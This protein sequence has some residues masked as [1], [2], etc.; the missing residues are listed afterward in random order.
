VKVS[1]TEVAGDARSR[2]GAGL[3]RL[4]D[5]KISL[6][7]FSALFLGA[8]AAARDGPISVPWLLLTVVGIFAIEVAKNA[9]G[10][11]F[12]F[13]SGTDLAVAREDRT[14]FS[15]G[16]R[17]L[18]ERLLT[19]KQTA[20]IAGVAYSLGI[21]A[22][23][24]IV[25]WREPRVLLL[26]FVGVAAALFYQAP[27]LRLSYR[28]LGEVAVGLCYGPLLTA[29][30]YLVQRGHVTR[31]VIAASLPLGLMIADFLLINEFP[32]ARADSQARKRTLVVRLGR[33]RASLLYGWVAAIAFALV[34]ALPSIGSP[35]SVWLG[36]LGLPPA[37]RTA[38]ILRAD[39]DTTA[40]L[41]PAQILT[42]VS[43]LL[44]ALGS[45]GGF[46][47]SR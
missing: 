14:P 2:L 46:L 3:W 32:D 38:W 47:L 1:A 23:L 33:R 37:V 15:G 35:R 25:A 30:T 19:R 40:R 29:G 11:I 16:K 39:P 20:A 18:V 24:S 36:L 13:D 8:C 27:P 7:S 42:L 6:A 44:L 10:E 28:G 4:A 22:G 41:I 21:A 34:F 45:G 9:S 26:G 43:F 31:E 12:D 17:V 5:P